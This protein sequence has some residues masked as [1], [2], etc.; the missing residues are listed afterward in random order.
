[1]KLL[2][3]FFP[4]S[5]A[6]ARALSTGGLLWIAHSGTLESVREFMESFQHGLR[7]ITRA[8][9]GAVTGCR[10]AGQLVCS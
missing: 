1:M 7:H 2:L 3:S 6:K 9:A 4:G 10:S 5:Q 8:L